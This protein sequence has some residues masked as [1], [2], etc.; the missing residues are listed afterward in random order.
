MQSEIL[1]LPGTNITP[2]SRT[3]ALIR[4]NPSTFILFHVHH[5]YPKSHSNTVH[6]VYAH[7]SVETWHVPWQQNPRHWKGATLLNLQV[8]IVNEI[9][10]S[11]QSVI[12]S[13]E[14][15]LTAKRGA[16]RLRLA[17]EEEW[18]NIGAALASKA[19][20]STAAAS[21]GIGL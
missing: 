8:A 21:C 4:P 15:T 19:E 11:S 16:G 5:S 18:L 7:V 2:L 6:P 20:V 13:Q 3:V 17:W 12:G 10:H 1:T 9:S 14:C